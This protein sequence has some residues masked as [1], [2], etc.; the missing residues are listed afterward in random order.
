MTLLEASAPTRV[1]SPA[2]TLLVA[3]IVLATLTE[4]IAGTVL[5]LGRADMIGDIHATPDEFAWL[6]T[7]YTALKLVGFM[8]APCCSTRVEPRRLV[9]AATLVMGAAS[10]IAAGT[11]RLDLLVALRA[12]QGFSAACCWSPAKPSSSSPCHCPA[13]RSC[14]RCLPWARSSHP[15]RS[16]RRCRAGC[17]TASPG[18]GSSSALFRWR[19]R[20]PDFCLIAD[21]PGPGRSRPARS[22]GSASR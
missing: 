12:L 21:L 7:A 3:G 17:S 8:V 9:I 4:A 10:G 11:A 20:P 6:D 15:R 19:W 18:H 22:T 13:S 1:R 2:A 16:R 14:R 5:S